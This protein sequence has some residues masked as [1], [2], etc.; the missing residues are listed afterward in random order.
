MSN[1]WCRLRISLA[2]KRDLLPSP[3]VVLTSL[4]CL[5]LEG[6]LGTWM[7]GGKLPVHIPGAPHR[8]SPV[9]TACRAV[10]PH[11][12]TP[13]LQLDLDPIRDGLDVSW[14]MAA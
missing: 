2:N 7:N 6:V 8:G 11:S 4:L 10:S 3:H 12:C 14:R 9:M 1:R 5:I 13:F